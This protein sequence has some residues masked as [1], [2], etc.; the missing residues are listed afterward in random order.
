M[1]KKEL[2][3]HK[4]RSF[5]DKPEH[6]LAWKGEFKS[7]V[8]ELQCS[9]VEKL[10]L[11]TS[12]LGPESTRQATDIRTSCANDR[13]KSLKKIWQCL[14]ERFG[15]PELVESALRHKLVNFT[16]FTDMK[17]LYTLH[18]VLNEIETAKRQPNYRDI[19]AGFDSS[20][21]IKP[22]LQKLPHTLQEKWMTRANMYKQT[23]KVLFP[24][25][26]KFVNFIGEMSR[27]RNDPGL[28]I[29]PSWR[30]QPRKERETV[31]VKKVQLDTPKQDTVS[32]R[33]LPWENCIFH[34]HNKHS[35]NRC[36][37]FRK[38]TMDKSISLL[39]EKNIC[40][41]CCETSSHF[42]RKC[43]ADI[44]C[45]VCGSTSKYHCSALHK[46][47]IVSRD[48]ESARNHGEETT[49]VVQCTEFCGEFNG[50]SCA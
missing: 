19:F 22:I 12:H 9:S 23:H 46:E 26:G 10:G 44:Q 17:K 24:P 1:L 15:S 20:V 21:G 14:E 47:Y 27:I 43:K 49:V 6:C 11:P 28:V 35:T 38:L 8:E 3:I 34:N 42:S 30:N 31:H 41:R 18:D 13:D 29:E 5:D 50:K 40:F 37:V 36:R 48:S 16:K 4:F 25:F 32:D 2:L 45:V 7:I 33:K 39:K